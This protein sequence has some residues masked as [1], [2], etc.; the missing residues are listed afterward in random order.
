MLCASPRKS[1]QKRN[2]NCWLHT[3]NGRHKQSITGGS[4]CP[5]A[6]PTHR[7]A[8]SQTSQNKKY[9]CI[10][11]RPFISLNGTWFMTFISLT[12]YIVSGSPATTTTDI[13]P[14]WHE[15]L[16]STS[17]RRENQVR[18]VVS[19]QQLQEND[20][21]KQAVG[22]KNLRIVCRGLCWKTFLKGQIISNKTDGWLRKVD[23]A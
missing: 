21:W 6:T 4:L 7:Q 11:N 17:D 20:S 22:N 13:Y 23:K 8:I 9:P 10:Q 16:S 3:S 18:R 5:L 15:Y 19:V 12:W 2:E 1:H 14:C